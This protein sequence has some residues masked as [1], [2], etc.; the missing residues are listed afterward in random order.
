VPR[1]FEEHPVEAHIHDA[2]PL[3][4]VEAAQ[5][6]DERLHQET[7]SGQEVAG[8]R[9][10]AAELRFL[11]GQGKKCVESHEHKAEALGEV[12]IAEVAHADRYAVAT[13]LLTQLCHH[14]SG[15]VDAVHLDTAGDEGEREAAR[16]YP[17]FQ[18]RPFTSQ[19]VQ[20][21]HLPRTSTLGP[22]VVDVRNALAVGSGVVTFHP[23]SLV[24]AGRTSKRFFVPE[25]LCLRSPHDL[26]RRLCWLN[27][28]FPRHRPMCSSAPNR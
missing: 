25:A 22:L 27:D 13:W 2:H 5:I 28:C 12:E 16:A 14:R 17:Q 1:T 6:G 10:E 3:A 7:P 9:S 8:N 20:Q 24:L 21:L 18:Y 23:Q 19:L 4:S 26:E 11:V 15:R